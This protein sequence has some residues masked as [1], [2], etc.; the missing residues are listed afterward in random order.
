MRHLIV[1]CLFSLV[2]CV[3]EEREYSAGVPREEPFTPPSAHQVVDQPHPPTRPV[4]LKWP[5]T[6]MC[7]PGSQ[8]TCANACAFLHMG[9]CPE[10]GEMCGVSLDECSLSPGDPSIVND[11]C[12]WAGDFQL[13]VTPYTQGDDCERVYWFGEPCNEQAQT[14]CCTMDGS[15]LPVNQ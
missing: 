11:P 7:R 6:P 9:E 1:V 5:E 3:A 2:S 15:S 14:Y 8:F 13:V 10:F 4:P 12:S